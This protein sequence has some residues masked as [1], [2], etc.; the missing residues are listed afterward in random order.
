MVENLSDMSEGF[1]MILYF[2][3]KFKKYFIYY[4]VLQDKLILIFIPVSLHTYI[5]IL[6]KLQFQFFT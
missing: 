2:R 6:F 1:V 3:K 5:I 4:S